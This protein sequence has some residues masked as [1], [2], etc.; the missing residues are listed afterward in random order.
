MIQNLDETVYERNKDDPDWKRAYD[1]LQESNFIFSIRNLIVHPGAS[2]GTDETY[3]LKRSVRLDLYTLE[4]EAGRMLLPYYNYDITGGHLAYS[5]KDEVM[6]FRCKSEKPVD[7]GHVVIHEGGT[8]ITKNV[9]ASHIHINIGTNSTLELSRCGYADNL[10]FFRVAFN[11]R[12][13]N[14]SYVNMHLDGYYP[15]S[16]EIGNNCKV[17]Y[18]GD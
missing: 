6:S 13:G 12:V 9:K 14:N 4:L 15:K 17:L 8:L 16:L 18:N 10:S 3:G 11:W 7:M 1:K 2:V 5:L